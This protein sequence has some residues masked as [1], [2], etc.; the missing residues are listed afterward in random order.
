MSLCVKHIT[1]VLSLISLI[2]ASKIPH[3]KPL[4]A[5]TGQLAKRIESP[6][7][8]AVIGDSWGSGV[9]YNNDVLYDNNLDNCLRTK[10]SHG[11]QMEADTSWTGSFSSGLRDA[12]CSGSRLVDLAKGGYQMGKVGTPNVVVMTSG[13]NNCGFGNIVEVCIYH[14][15]F[16]KNYGPA[17]ADDT[18]GT[19]MC[20]QALNNALN[21]ITNSLQQDLT[22]TINDILDDPNVKSNPDFLLYLT[23]YA[24]FFGTDHDP[25]C[26]KEAWNIPSFV[27]TPTPYLSAQLRTAFNDRVTKVNNLYKSVIQDNF[28]NQARFVD[29]DPGFEG[30]RFCEPGASHSDQ[31]NRD[32]HFENVYLWNLNYP[33]LGAIQVTNTTAPNP[34]EQNGTLT[35]EEAQQLFGTNGVT[36]WSGS[37]SGGE[38]NTPENGWRLRPF[39][40]R[41]TGYTSIQNAILVQL[42]ADGLPKNGPPPASPAPSSPPPYVPGTCSFH[43]KETQ[44]CN[45]DAN[46]LY[47]IVKMY[48]N[49]KNVIG[50]TVQD[51]NHPSG[52]AMDVGNSYSFASK[53][54]DPL[55][56]TGEHEN[57]YV[58]FTLGSLSWQSKTPNGGGSCKI[59]GWDPKGGPV[60]SRLGDSIAVSLIELLKRSLLIRNTGEQHGLQ[61]PLL[62]KVANS[63]RMERAETDFYLTGW[64][65]TL[66]GAV[67]LHLRL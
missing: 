20:A 5:S 34:D 13:G 14:P 41:Y 19:G 61:L 12:A 58:Q 26:N 27:N 4:S 36:A 23:G 57:D 24:L 25:W 44:D 37:G 47:G 3:G 15:N 1:S 2:A 52:Y 46:N 45:S 30:H 43:L 17:Y 21:Y 54:K 16:L 67:E 9:S 59:G 55:I 38:A 39:H 42:K 40:P 8:Y 11:P 53:L 62:S 50:Q 32:T 29:L 56:I 64:E 22:N 66:R 33:P 31:F 35:S 51:D 6:W 18:D 63:T 10:E 60:C 28:P 65:H 48:D 7:P 49:D